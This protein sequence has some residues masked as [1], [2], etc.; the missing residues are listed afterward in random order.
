MADS[1]SS[2]RT[3]GFTLVEMMVALVFTSLLMAGMASVF[4]ASLSTFYT[5]GETTSSNRR[6][7]ISTDLLGDDLNNACLSLAN[8]IS[9]PTLFSSTN[10]PF[11]ILPNT[12]FS[13][14]PK[15]TSNS[16]DELYFYMDQALPFEGTVSTIPS[17]SLA[18]HILNGTALGSADFT[19]TIACPNSAYANLVKQGM[20]CLFMDSWDPQ[21]LSSVTP[22][23]NNVTVVLGPDPNSFITGAGS[24]GLGTKTH[25]ASTM[26]QFVQPSQ[27]VRYQVRNLVLDPNNTNT[28]PCLVRD[29]IAASGSLGFAVPTGQ[30]PQIIAENVQGFKV[31]LSVDSGKTWA[32]QDLGTGTTGFT[33][34]W[35]NGLLTTDAN[36]ITT[37]LTNNSSSI[38]GVPV[39]TLLAAPDWFRTL[40]TLVRIDI[41]TRTAIARTEYSATPNTTN[42]KTLTQ[43]L[44]FV[45]RHSGLPMS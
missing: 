23:G 2:A 42:Y 30:N 12:F 9:I 35:T 28:I 36:S 16:C 13:G 5:S 1:R 15:T 25:L 40:P 10:P 22:N 3:K 39:T 38:L 41:T 44:V 17:T 20:Y 43:S 27:M 33:A 14:T 7:H 11:Y 24:T 34:G 26:I 37:Q 45:P 6:N 19:Y 8:L 29:Q 31:Y 32:G 18:E 4:K 21:Y